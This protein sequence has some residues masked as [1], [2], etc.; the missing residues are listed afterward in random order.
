[1]SLDNNLFTLVLANSEESPGDFDCTD[2]RTGQVLYR[3]RRRN[4]VKGPAY[5]WLLLDPMF[6]KPI[7]CIRTRSSHL[8]T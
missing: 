5:H 3:K 2:P 4:T 7:L 8:N 1:M 6:V